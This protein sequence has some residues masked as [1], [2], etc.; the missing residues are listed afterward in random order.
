VFPQV[1]V[2][3]ED[4]YPVRISRVSIDWI[5]DGIDSDW[6]GVDDADRFSA[7]GVSDGQSD[8]F[9]WGVNI[10]DCEVASNVHF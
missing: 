1:L 5:T 4:S 8:L 10:V 2:N 3:A 7:G 6:G 9:R